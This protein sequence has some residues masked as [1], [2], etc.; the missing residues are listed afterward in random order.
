MTTTY[1]A[2]LSHC[3]CYKC[4]IMFGIP[5]EYHQKLKDHGAAFF[6]PVGHQQHY[7]ETEMTRLR[8]K[9]ERAERAVGKAE[10]AT[11]RERAEHDQ[12]REDLQHTEARRR[13][14]KAAKTRIKKRLAKGVCPCCNRYFENLRRHMDGQHPEFEDHA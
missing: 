3:E 7:M 1:Y 10:R 8:Q 13:G 6:C 12:T 11:V 14:E 5:A 9:V 2:T 4:G